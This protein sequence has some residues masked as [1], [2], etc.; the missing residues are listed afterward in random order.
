MMLGRIDEVDGHFIATRFVALVVPTECL[1]IPSKTTLAGRA[2][3]ETGS[4]AP[5][6][7]V[8]IR[9]EWRSLGLA[10][11]RVWLP[12][13][14][15]AA[16]LAQLRSG[17][18]SLVTWLLS[19]AMLGAC[20]YTHRCGRLSEEE[21]ARLRVLGTVTGLRIEPAKLLP[22]TREV[23]R[24][25]LGEL[26]EKAGLPMT[27]RELIAVLDD[28]PTPAMPLVYGYSCYAG[29]TPEW[30]ECAALAYARCEPD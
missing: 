2:R 14:A 4:R 24:A 27:P 23:K 21:K 10:Y 29:D 17:H 18:V 13:L 12:I 8:R 15:I 7:G 16:P 26:M 28:I 1:Y 3:S 19:A 25:S 11:A 6:D 22:A 5:H 30:E 9:T 20:A